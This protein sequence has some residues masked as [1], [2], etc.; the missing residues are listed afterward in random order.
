MGELP[1]YLRKKSTKNKANKK[2]KKVLKTLQSGALDYKG[3]FQK[4]RDT[5][6]EFKCPTK[7]KK[8]F[9]IT[10]EILD[11]AVIDTINMGRENTILL[12]ELEKYYIIGK[13]VRK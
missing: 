3:D 2:E 4:D 9:R 12:I 8:S 7:K 13:V 1:K 11:K 5:I 10:E 6:I